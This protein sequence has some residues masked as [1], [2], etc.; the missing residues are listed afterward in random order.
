MLWISLS[1]SE[2]I[3]WAILDKFNDCLFRF[4]LL[5]FVFGTC[6]R[7]IYKINQRHTYVISFCIYSAKMHIFEDF[8]PNPPH[9]PSD[10]IFWV[11]FFFLP[12]ENSW[13]CLPDFVLIHMDPVT[14][15]AR[16]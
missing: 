10:P 6:L 12:V 13:H 4:G 14:G 1:A 16:R 2:C 9:H 15:E 5:E 7:S 3:F 11:V 8:Y